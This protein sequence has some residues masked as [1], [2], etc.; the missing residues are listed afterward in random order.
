MGAL[1]RW[2][3]GIDLNAGCPIAEPLAARLRSARDEIT[4]R[5]LARIVD[6]VT[7][8][9][10]QVFP[11]EELINH[12]PLL[13]SAIADFIADPAEDVTTINAVV[14]KAVELGEL[15]YQQ[16]FGPQQILKEFEILGGIM[17]AELTLTAE[18]ITPTCSPSE[19]FVCAHRLHRA[20]AAILQV[21]TT[22]YLR[23]MD[24]RV[25]EREQRL[26][27][28]NRMVSH[29]LKNR[30]HAAQSA[31]SVLREG[32]FDGA[33]RGRLL[34]IVAENLE[35]LSGKLNDLLELSRIDPAARRQRNV[36]LESAVDESIRHVRDLA[37]DRGVTIRI[38]DE[39]PR[40]EVNSAAV[41]LCLSNYLSNAVKYADA[42]QRARWVEITARLQED[43]AYGSEL[44]VEVRDNG[45]GV[46]EAARSEL[47]KRFFR[48][49]SATKE[50]GSGLG[51]SIVRETV[52]ALGGRAWATFDDESGSCF[53]FAL[54]S[55]RS[56][57]G[58]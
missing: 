6:R 53:A 1:A 12:V 18:R 35:A 32:W 27:G 46:P 8:E 48:A 13:V 54:P 55:R 9:A 45:V 50:E 11:S 37:R 21:T 29:E 57:D 16:A 14:A 56:E 58:R 51:L 4:R 43:Q 17:L 49:E 7:V 22:H 2:N 30:A 36:L 41:E 38:A 42:E 15:R 5:W 33:A 47:F 24:A 10:E 28:F 20:L 25:N 44:V 34:R 3:N 39:L 40:V 19:V 31:A 26:R 23:L 52:E